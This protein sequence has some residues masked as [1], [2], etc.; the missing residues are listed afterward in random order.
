MGANAE[1]LSELAE[2]FEL[3]AEATER[4]LG[5]YALFVLEHEEVVNFLY[6]HLYAL[7]RDFGR[8]L[9]RN[10]FA[11]VKRALD[12]VQLLFGEAQLK[13]NRSVIPHYGQVSNAALSKTNV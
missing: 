13:V 3:A 12:A 11:Q 4:L 8:A 5:E 1:Q 2:A 7:E 9:C 10:D 6:A